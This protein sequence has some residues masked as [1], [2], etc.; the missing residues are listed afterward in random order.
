MGIE[1][2]SEHRVCPDCHDLHV[3]G[4][5]TSFDYHYGDEA[6]QRIAECEDGLAELCGEDGVM[7]GGSEEVDEFSWSP[8]ECCGCTFGGMRHHV[9]ILAPAVEVAA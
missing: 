1:I 9:A 4:D 6:D 8:C 2:R 7:V 3:G 5:A